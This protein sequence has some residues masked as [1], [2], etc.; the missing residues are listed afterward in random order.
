MA[1][2]F[3][4]F[5]LSWTPLILIMVLAVGFKRQALELALWGTIYTV[6]LT[7]LWFKTTPAVVA[8]AGLDGVLTNTALLLVI[9][10]GMLLSGLLLD[11]GSLSRVVDWFSGLTRNEWHRTVLITVGV[12]N[13]MEGSGIVAEPIVA[14]ML[15][16]SGLPA[17]GA[18]ALSIAG[19]SG[20][21]ILELGGAILTVLALVTGLEMASLGWDV[22]L[23]SIPATVLMSLSI[24]W[25]LDQPRELTKQFP[26]LLGVGLLAGGGA[27]F[28]VHYLGL[29]VSGLFG[30][31]LVILVL[32]L[33]GGRR[34]RLDAALLKDMAPFI[35][36]VV[37]LFSVN[38]ITPLKRAAL[39]AWPGAVSVV[40]GH[41]IHFRPLYSAFTYIFLAYLLAALLVNDRTLVLKSFR[42]T[43][44]RAWRPILAMALFGAA[45][46]I[47]AYSGFQPGFIEMNPSHNIALTL[48]NGMVAISGQFY[49]VFAPL[50]GWTGTF[51]TG[52]GTA[53]IVLFGKLHV[54]TATLLGVSPSLLA[55]GMA[56]GSAVGSISSPLK[57]ALAASMCG[58]EG[59]EGWILARTIPLGIGLALILGLI[60][61]MMI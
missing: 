11:T 35:L 16:A 48:A 21:M 42:T 50:I 47:I 36:L 12:G 17:T 31:L 32:S 54:S 1:V 13:F 4:N 27:L 24:P 43:N 45:G 38:L 9:Y 23:L 61:L 2:D 19:Y 26:L 20:L 15:R 18:A 3:I 39:E 49:P 6:G 44:L 8:L 59:R 51:L 46:Q 5:F 52:Y 41:L 40:P 58:A 55:S 10:F 56:V 53:S 28:A 34:F 60:L 25:L 29:T 22:G 57:I 30:G 14:P 7:L 33:A 37:S